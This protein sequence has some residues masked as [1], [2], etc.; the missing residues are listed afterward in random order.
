MTG[1]AVSGSVSIRVVCR[2]VSGLEEVQKVNRELAERIN[3]EARKDPT[4]PYAGK[5][6]GIANGE[7]V[8]KQTGRTAT[9]GRLT[10]TAANETYLM[11]GKPVI[12]IE[13]AP[14]DCKRSEGTTLT[15][16][17]SVDT[18]TMS[19][20]GDRILAKNIPCPAGK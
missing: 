15:F 9:G 10:Y 12:A 20:D 6:V 13:I 5:Y 1:N 14:P 2:R 3:R 4:S 7:V 16:Q 11:T 19:G 17:K 18:T 8:V